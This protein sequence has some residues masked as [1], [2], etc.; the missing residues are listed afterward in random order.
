MYR[1]REPEY[2]P[3]ERPHTAAASARRPV[4][5]SLLDHAPATPAPA[6]SPKSPARAPEPRLAAT[7]APATVPASKPTPKPAKLRKPRPES[8]DTDRKFRFQ[9]QMR[10]QID[11]LS[12]LGLTDLIFWLRRGLVLIVAATLIGIVAAFLYSI[13]ATP[14]YT[15]YT[16]LIVDPQNLNLVADDVFSSSQQRDSQLLDVESKLRVLTSRNVLKQVIDEMHLTTDPEFNKPPGL[17]SSLFSSRQGSASDAETA[18]MRELGD[19]VTATREERSF[20]VTLAVWA[21]DPDKSIELSQA[22]VRAFEADLFQSS[23]ESAGRLAA[24]LN[25]RLQDLKASVSAA[26]EKV[27]QFKRQN[28]IQASTTGELS[29]SRISSALDT[30]VLDAQQRMIQADARYQQM[31]AAVADRRITTATVFDSANMQTLRGSYNLVQQQIGALALTY[32]TRHPRLV[33]LQSEQATLEK[34][35]SDEA[36]RILASAKADADQSRAAFGAIRGK[37]DTERSTVFTDND[38][39]VTLRE[40][41]R[42]ARAK[43]A[44]YETYLGRTHQIAERQQIDTSNVRVI[45]QPVAPKARSWPPRSVILLAAGAIGGFASGSGLALAFGLAGHLR[46]ARRRFADGEAYA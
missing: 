8:R 21:S 24:S 13:T 44:V 3:V 33:T 40:L 43:A 35:I 5:R 26:E 38:A 23:A 34:A 28:N 36:N 9:E 1:P 11:S 19:R 37:A 15:V 14:R 16:D 41:E 30:Q 39:Q 27:E 12:E 45:S 32:G 10:A 46:D 22:I 6:R 18:I 2:R 17:F 7:P 25:G 4:A 29:S 42:D 20:V 31:R